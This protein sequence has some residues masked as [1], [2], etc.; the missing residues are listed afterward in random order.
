MSEV[1][2][3]PEHL[4]TVTLQTDNRVGRGVC[5]S[6]S[7]CVSTC[8]SSLSKQT[9]EAKGACVSAPAPVFALAYRHLTTEAKGACVSAQAPVL[10]LAYRHK[11]TTK[12]G[13][14]RAP[15]L[16]A[17]LSEQRTLTNRGGRC[18]S[19]GVGTCISSLSSRQQSREEHASQHKHL[20]LAIAYHMRVK[21]AMRPMSM[22]SN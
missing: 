17:S 7:T 12:E 20:C 3:V 6:A 22:F 14:A 11:Q 13:K 15:E 18:I 4:H 16:I 10:A 19:T 5:L 2:R 1:R 8:I 21:L 9:T